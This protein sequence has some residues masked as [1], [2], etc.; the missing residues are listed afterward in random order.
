MTMMEFSEWLAETP[1]SQLIQVTSWAIPALQ[2]VHIIS[3]STL[4]AAALVLALRI[5]GHG[6]VAE[7]LPSIAARFLPVVWICLLLLLL[8]GSL[9]VTAEPGRTITNPVFYTK[10]TLVAAAGAIT[11]WLGAV[12]RRQLE[13]PSA[14]HVAAAAVSLLLW[15]G[16]M[17]AGRYIAYVESY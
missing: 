1:V 2:V 3:L 9:L 6:L 11:L 4:F 5:A 14:V 13:R 7:A 10:M 17:I 12:S 15:A 8:T 16:I